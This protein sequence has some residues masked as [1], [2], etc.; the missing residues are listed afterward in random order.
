MAGRAQED[1][2][3]EKLLQQ[4]LIKSS[5]WKGH[6]L[7]QIVF[8]C[9]S[10]TLNHLLIKSKQLGGHLNSTVHV[11]KHGQEVQTIKNANSHACKDYL[12]SHYLV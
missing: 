9:K 10:R 6:L 5:S 3:E 2:K 1:G 11:I 12:P 4:N 7:L 8:T